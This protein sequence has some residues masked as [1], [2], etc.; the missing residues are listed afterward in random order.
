MVNEKEPRNWL[1]EKT[2]L[3]R[4]HLRRDVQGTERQRLD[5]Q[6]QIA[7]P[8]IGHLD[9]TAEAVLIGESH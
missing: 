7:D 6:T 4:Q 8:G 3:R 1:E 9:V 5:I 2:S